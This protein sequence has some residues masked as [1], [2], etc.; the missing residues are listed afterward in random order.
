MPGTEISDTGI[1]V[2]ITINYTLKLISCPSCACYLKGI[3]MIVIFVR[4]M[5]S[6][7]QEPI[8]EID[9]VKLFNVRLFIYSAYVLAA[10]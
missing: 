7:K 2:L 4:I 6:Q 1:L 9:M 3:R 5:G 8:I 10:I